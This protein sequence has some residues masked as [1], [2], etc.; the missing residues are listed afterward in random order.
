MIE[1]LPVPI[2]SSGNTSHVTVSIGVAVW[3]DDGDSLVE[4]L[5]IA[6]LRLY[7]AKGS[8]RNRVVTTT[9]EQEKGRRRGDKRRRRG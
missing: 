9:L 1:K 2:D 7:Q 5:S 4:A 3:P 8:G 6:D